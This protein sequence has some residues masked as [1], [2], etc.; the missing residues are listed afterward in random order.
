MG[1][2]KLGK[3]PPVDHQKYIG[4]DKKPPVG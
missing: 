2:D 4:G 1:G 3:E